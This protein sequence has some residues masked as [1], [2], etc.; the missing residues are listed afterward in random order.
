MTKSVCLIYNPRSGRPREREYAALEFSSLLKA[1]GFEVEACA[2][3]HRNHATDL[4]RAAVQRNFDLVVANGGDGTLNEVLQG[5]IGSAVPLAIWPGGTGNVLATDLKIPRLPQLVADMIALDQRKRICVGRAGERYFF[6]AAGIGL[7]AEIINTVNSE[8]K[9]TIGKGAFWIAGFS[10]L[11]K[12]NPTL[13]T[14]QI[15]GR[16]YEGTFAVIGNSH[17][18]GGSISITPQARL[19]E[20]MLDVCIFSGRSKL[21]YINYLVA[22]MNKNQLGHKGVT[23]LKT[24]YLEASS[25][26]ALPVQVDGEVVGTLPMTF[27]IIP[28][29]LTLI[30]PPG[31]FC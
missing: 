25:L 21:Q 13:I 15:D 27:Q 29:A 9:K 19:D 26:T 30:V 6:F 5:M 31:A 3:Q 22:A 10:H 28:D 11:V 17:G 7:D 2:T 23:Y 12:W 24:R 8:L 1:R 4:A 14:L 16:S 18:Y 20:D